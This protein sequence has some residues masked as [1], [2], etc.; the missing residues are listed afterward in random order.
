MTAL[1]HSCL[2]GGVLAALCLAVLTSCN[3]SGGTAVLPDLNAPHPQITFLDRSSASVGDHVVINGLRFGTSQSGGRVTLTNVDFTVLSWSDT[4]IE[5]IVTAG[6]TS[7]IVVVSVNGLSSQNGSEAQLFIPTAPTEPPILNALSPDIAEV[8]KDQVTLTGMN[9]GTSTGASG[10]FFAARASDGTEIEV[11]ANVVTVNIA[12]TDVP[13]WTNATIRV[14][15][16]AT[17]ISG[18]VFVRVNGVQSNS[19]GFTARHIQPT[20]PPDITGFTP[21][22]G[23]VGTVVTIAGE[24]FGFQQSGSVVSIGDL[25]MGGLSM[26]APYWSDTEIRA[27]IPTGAVTA[28]IHVVVAA[29]GA[30]SQAAFV[31]ANPPRITG[32]SPSK[33]K[34]GFPVTIYGLY[35]GYSQGTGTLHIGGTNVPVATWNDNTI[36]VTTLPSIAAKPGDPLPVVVTQGPLS[37]DPFNVTL[38]SDLS[39]TL[40]VDPA[41]GEATKT[42]FSFFATAEGGSGQYTFTLYPDT[43]NPGT[44][45]GGTSTLPIPYT[46]QTPGTYQTQIKIEDVNTHDATYV[47]GPQVLV[48]GVGEPVITS[49]DL[50]SYNYLGAGNLPIDAPR[51]N[52]CYYRKPI[53]DEIS[54]YDFSFYAGQLYYTS[55]FTNLVAPGGL[56]LVPYVRDFSLYKYVPPTY[57]A[58]DPPNLLDPG[59]SGRPYGFRYTPIVPN[60]TGST[61]IVRG[62]NFGTNPDE[63]WLNYDDPTDT[64]HVQITTGVTWADKAVIFDLPASVNKDF[65][66][67]V[68]LVIGGTAVKSPQPLLCSA[69]ITAINGKAVPDPVSLTTGTI[70]VGGFDFRVPTVSGISG[71]RAYM[72]WTVQATFTDPWPPNNVVTRASLLLTPIPV[73]LSGNGFSFTMT[74]LGIPQGGNY[75]AQVEVFN[76]ANTETDVVVGQL[77]AGDYTLSLWTGALGEGTFGAIAKSGLFSE[78]K[79]IPVTP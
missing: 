46:Y 51:N 31:V 52:Q 16:P 21:A 5:A 34:V 4:R 41:A 44:T 58:Q 30:K 50:L 59:H 57:D 20:L 69:L 15:V 66:G 49:V 33:L 65:S 27:I 12:G 78:S 38:T 9:F 70:A 61:V 26:N 2:V 75:F 22:N 72:I 43:A 6:M 45:A 36:T 54:Y 53:T 42:N 47:D 37:S 10:V 48:V 55:P 19:K 8:G 76:V 79:T 24:N 56:E 1:K 62:L 73:T 25:A 29:Q 18:G 7:G 28:E 40:T 68:A 67:T 17:A 60:D 35:F 64:N 39:G 74:D 14:W 63:V 3:G 13:Q 11:Q 77:A 71:D 23:P 32:V